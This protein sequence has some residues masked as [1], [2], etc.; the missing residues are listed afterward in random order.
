MCHSCVSSSPG[1]FPR[2]RE[3]RFIPA[4]AGTQATW[5]LTFFLDSRL[6]GNDTRGNDTAQ[7]ASASPGAGL[8]TAWGEAGCFI[9]LKCYG[10]RFRGFCG[11]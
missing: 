4:Q 2:K 10:N 1:L 7:P 9:R 11:G 5:P 3:S 8:S 6:R